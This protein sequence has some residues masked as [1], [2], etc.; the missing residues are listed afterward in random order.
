MAII[1]M[2]GLAVLAPVY[3]VVNHYR[4]YGKAKKALVLG[5]T[6]ESV[7]VPKRQYGDKI[8]LL[9]MIIAVGVIYWEL[10]KYTRTSIAVFTLFQVPVV[11]LATYCLKQ[12]LKKHQL[13]GKYNKIITFIFMI[14]LTAIY[15]I[16]LSYFSIL[17]R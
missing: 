9:G 15:T 6:M 1:T 17:H 12:I 2:L 16:L 4:I 10:W 14:I 8:I 13:T 3:L 5:L 7:P 11:L